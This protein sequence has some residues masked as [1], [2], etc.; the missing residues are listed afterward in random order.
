VLVAP[1]NTGAANPQL[2]TLRHPADAVLGKA[3]AVTLDD[4]QPGTFADGTNFSHA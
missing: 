1:W 2:G 4:P 3:A